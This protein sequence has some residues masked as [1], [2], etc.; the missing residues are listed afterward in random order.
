MS[1]I[2]MRMQ[3]NSNCI[4]IRTGLKKF[5]GEKQCK[6]RVVDRAWKHIC[7]QFQLVLNGKWTNTWA[8]FIYIFFFWILFE[9]TFNFMVHMVEVLN[10]SF[11]WDSVEKNM[12]GEIL[13]WN[14]RNTWRD[15]EIHVFYTAQ[16]CIQSNIF[17]KKTNQQPN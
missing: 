6:K 1:T 4:N 17:T 10:Y 14:R 13:W 16:L 15:R 5:S 7:E 3:R 9:Q 12:G 2:Q 8:R 11:T